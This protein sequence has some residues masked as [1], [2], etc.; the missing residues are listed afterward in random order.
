MKH[1]SYI[2]DFESWKKAFNFYTEIK[3]R[4]SE[5]DMFGHMNNVSAFIYFEQAR[6][7][8]LNEMGF[9]LQSD[10]EGIPIVADLQCDYI[11]Q[12]YF[13]DTLKVYVKAN[14]IGTSSIDLH[15]MVTNELEEICLTGRG[16]LVYIDQKH[17]KPIP[18]PHEMKEKL[19]NV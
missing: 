13:N 10:Y 14:N 3:V 9:S 7:E 15:Y 6:I 17:H 8:F 19:L 2:K 12:I 4:F 5:T 16:T 18:I 1:I 11:N